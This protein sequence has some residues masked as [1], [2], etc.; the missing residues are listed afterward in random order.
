MPVGQPKTV[1]HGG[2]V[3]QIVVHWRREWQTT[4]VHTISILYC[5]YLSLGISDFLEDVSSFSPSFVFFCLCIDHLKILS[6][7]TLLFSGT[8]HS[9]GYIF[10]F[11]GLPWWLRW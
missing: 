2:E 9:D 4:S 11:L 8:L 7:L 10:P 3:S 6:Y 1:G 5:A